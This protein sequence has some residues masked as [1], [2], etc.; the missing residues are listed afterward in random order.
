[1]SKR[2]YNLA[3][4]LF[5]PVQRFDLRRRRDFIF[6]FRR[7][8]A[9]HSEVC[10]IATKYSTNTARAG[11]SVAR[12]TQFSTTY[13]CRTRRRYKYRVIRRRPRVTRARARTHT[14]DGTR[15]SSVSTNR[16]S[17]FF[18]FRYARAALNAPAGSKN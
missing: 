6:Y 16:K 15:R 3:Y 18:H 4:A 13:Y 7:T 5:P 2:I 9:E 1:M 14:P 12:E 11:I 10:L 8:L 17:C